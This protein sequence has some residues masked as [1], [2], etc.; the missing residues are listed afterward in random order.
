MCEFNNRSEIRT[1][2]KCAI[3]RVFRHNNFTEEWFN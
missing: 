1:V 3:Y 2:R